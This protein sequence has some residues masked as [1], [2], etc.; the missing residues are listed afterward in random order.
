MPWESALQ[1]GIPKRIGGRE[2]VSV[3]KNMVRN[4]KPTDDTVL[5]TMVQTAS[6]CVEKIWEDQN[7]LVK[8]FVI[9]YQPGNT[10]SQA[11]SHLCFCWST[12]SKI[13]CSTKLTTETTEML[14]L[15][16][17]SLTC[18]WKYGAFPR[19]RPGHND[20]GQVGT[21]FAANTKTASI[22]SHSVWR[23]KRKTKFT[24]WPLF[25]KRKDKKD[26]TK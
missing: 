9:F 14:P 8:W 23:S 24:C 1:I 13:L 15:L 7:H 4:N 3:P 18:R 10:W 16:P 11:V 17:S 5:F 6:S 20:F 19:Q 22:L 2:M 21:R 12:L 25:L 26:F